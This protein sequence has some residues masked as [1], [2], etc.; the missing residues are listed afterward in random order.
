LVD[1]KDTTV[2]GLIW[3]TID[4]DTS[5]FENISE[6]IAIGYRDVSREF[7]VGNHVEIILEGAVMES[8][9]MQAVADAV[10]VNEKR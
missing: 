1:S 9:P 6:D 2:N 4:E 3:I 5:F 8:Y 7:Q 10:T